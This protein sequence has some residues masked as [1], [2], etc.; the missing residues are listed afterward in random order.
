M[1]NVEARIIFKSYTMSKT[2]SFR[3]SA[4]LK[5]FIQ[6]DLRLSLHTTVS[7]PKAIHTAKIPFIPIIFYCHTI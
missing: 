2:K 4:L 3:I 7:H 6:L 1:K 5:Y